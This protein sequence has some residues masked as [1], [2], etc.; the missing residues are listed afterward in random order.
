MKTTPFQKASTFVIAFFFTLFLAPNLIAQQ[1]V[2]ASDIM[3][4]IKDGKNVTYENVTITGTLDMTYMDSKLPDLPK[5]KN[6]FN[7]GGSNTVKEQIEG[8]ISFV[9]CVFED[10]VFA[11]IHHEDSGY[12]FIANFE[13]DVQFVNC[14]FKSNA[15]FKYSDFERNADFKGSKFDE[16]TTFK[17]AKFDEKVSFS[18][19]T[20]REDAIFKYTEF[21]NGVSFNNA[22]F[23]GNLNLKYTKVKGDFDIK[24]MDVAYD[25]DS[26][27]TKINGQSF[28]KHLVSKN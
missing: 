27:Y 5:K 28:S 13:N 4:D 18:N 15:L 14:T 9:N 1:T 22:N 19:T 8:K 17:Y 12:T 16:N 24:G 26:K 7:N 11:Y 3:Q 2:K 21:R 23:K 6:W 25:I 10:N 20:F